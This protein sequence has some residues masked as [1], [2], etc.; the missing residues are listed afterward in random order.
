MQDRLHTKLHNALYVQPFFPLR[1]IYPGSQDETTSLHSFRYSNCF[2]NDERKRRCLVG[3]RLLS[4]QFDSITHSELG[5]NPSRIV[6]NHISTDYPLLLSNNMDAVN[7]TTVLPLVVDA[8]S[9]VQL[10]VNSCL[11]TCTVNSDWPFHTLGL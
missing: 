5:A 8:T 3:W 4:G 7:P 1:M 11:C 10:A 9:R 6:Q 2:A